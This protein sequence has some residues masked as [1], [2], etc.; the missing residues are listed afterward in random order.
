RLL[1]RG[2]AAVEPDET[3]VVA[4][5]D[6]PQGV[7][8]SATT[9]TATYTIVNDDTATGACVPDALVE[10]VEGY[11]DNR[12]SGLGAGWFRVLV[13]FGERRANDWTGDDR[14]ITPM[15]AS[16]A[17][18][19][20]AL[21]H[22]W[23]PVADALECLEGT[24]TSTDPEVTVTGGSAVTEGGNAVFTVSADPAPTSSLT[25]TLTVADDATSDFLSAG[26]EGTRTVTLS[27][28]Q[29]ATTLTVA[30]QDD[31][32]DE[33]DGSVTATVAAGNGYRVG[34]PAAGTVAVN[35]NDATPQATPVVRI[36]A[37]DAI[38]E[39]G[40]AR[41]TLTASPAPQGPITVR[42][43]VTQSGAFAGSGQLGT[44]T[45]AMGTDG[46]A[47]LTVATVNDTTVETDGSLTATVQTGTGYTPHGTQAAA[48]V[49]VSD[50]DTPPVVPPVVSI[51]AGDA[52]TEGGT[53]QFTLTASPAP[54]SALTVDVQVRQSGAFAG[55][56]QL[57][58]RT[59]TVGTDGTATLTVSTV[60]DSTVEADGSL[61]ATVRTG[62]GYRVAAA[63]D[64]AASVRV[65]DDDVAPGTPTLSVADATASESNR[66]CAGGYVSCM[67]FTVTLSHMPADQKHGVGFLY[68]TREST[69][70]SASESSDYY[71][72]MGTARFWPGGALSQTVTVRLADDSIDEGPETFDLVIS[73]PDG[74]AVITDGVAEGT[75]T[76]SDPMPAAWL[77]RFGRTVAEQAL[78]GIAHRMAAPRTAGVEGAFAGRALGA[79]HDPAAPVGLSP[80]PAQS[81][82][83]H[84]GVGEAQ[85]QTLTL[86]EALLGSHF[87]ATG[88]TDA[89]GG[90]LAFWGR[91]AHASFDGREGTFSLDGETTTALL[92]ADYARGDWLLGLAL[93]QSEG[94]GA[95]RDTHIA[96]RPATQDCPG[97]ETLCN[98]AIR[99]GDGDVEASLTT[100]MPYAALEAS[101]RLKLWGALGV[102]AG[103]VTLKPTMGDTLESDIDWTMAAAGARSA[104]LGAEG[105]GGLALALVFDALWA[106]T[107]S[108]KTQ[109]LA[110]SESDVTRL[111]LGLEG[112]WRHPLEG[113]G[114]FTPKLEAGMRHDGGDAETGFGVELGGGLVWSAPTLGLNLDL[115]GRTL[116]AHGDDD[117]K[118]RGFAASFTFDPDPASERGAS[119]SLRQDWGGQTQGGLDALFGADTL[120]DRTGGGE[121]HS[122]WTA[123]AA[124]GLP[125]LG[126]RFTGSPH[127]GIGLSTGARDYTL[128]WRLTPA[129]GAN[130][131]DLSFG[132]Q[133]T[134]R[135]SDA[136]APEHTL[137]VELGARW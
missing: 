8:I 63:P 87:T 2:D 22:G 95:F 78:D 92:G 98:D 29:S 51:E 83:G 112:R 4:L 64:D 34:S 130:V 26:D 46:T 91:A 121:T 84:G 109:D 33:P 134:R 12:G 123:E 41:F 115:S 90:S 61:T 67:R 31:G 14:I 102:G 48:T 28:G 35:D 1:I 30:T 18:Q 10:T 125:A 60:N 77:A 43:Q 135:E 114:H 66:D 5:R 107:S 7:T 132:V 25:V 119:F 13:A 93:A 45:V 24:T 80:P 76:N 56:G 122:R 59:V 116:L 53:A 101:E 50:D 120:E 124:Y 73:Y 3:V 72:R 38:T 21:W 89:S 11:Y 96:P 75:I 118:D 86:H 110:A 111:R 54:A 70:K 27:G 85:P 69:P 39:G 6:P 20:A 97:D 108:D 49:A 36:A 106:R 23:G 82:I 71:H 15:P 19:Q 113:G 104:L 44:R 105:E 68:Y 65:A 131:F 127:A 32:A 79:A 129:A 42:M 117:L 128:G 99:E 57:G 47:V 136:A 88:A 133:A 9:G 81:D 100:A 37:G 103:Q 137:G 52:I 17:R 74:G 58:T 55:S 40:T 126:G 62:T 94:D 16:V